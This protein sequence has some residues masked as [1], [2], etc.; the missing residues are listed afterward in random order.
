MVEINVDQNTDDWL[1]IRR[2]G[3][4]RKDDPDDPIDPSR[5]FLRVGGSEVASICGLCPF[6]GSKPHEKFQQILDERWEYLQGSRPQGIA[7][8]AAMTHG[9]IAEPSTLAVYQRQM[10]Q[11]PQ[12]GVPCTAAFD[13][14]TLRVQAGRYFH[15]EQMPAVHGCSP[16]GLV[17]CELRGGGGRRPILRLVEAKSPWKPLYPSTPAYY[18]PQVQYQMWVTGIA[19]CDFVAVKFPRCSA[20]A[21]AP[22]VVGNEPFMISRH[23]I[24]VGFCEWMRQVVEHFSGQLR[25]ATH[26]AVKYTAPTHLPP[27]PDVARGVLVLENRPLSLQEA[28]GQPTHLAVGQPTPF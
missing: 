3:P 15:T 7:I 4:V 27:A 26:R 17:T 6:P 23:Q 21:P 8:T 25:D 20:G 24:D 19:E 22:A 18:V 9:S 13:A 1:R 16:D 10:R 11:H 12:H 28:G 14:A 2:G 5:H